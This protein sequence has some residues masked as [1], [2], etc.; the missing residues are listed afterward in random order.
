[1]PAGI[2][3]YL[4]I[5]LAV[6]LL[7]ET[8]A[9]SVSRVIVPL[10]GLPKGLD[11]FRIVHLSDLHGRYFEA[12]GQLM[13]RIR[14][15][16]PDIIALTGDY[17]HKKPEVLMHLLP[18]FAALAET[19]PVFAVPGNHDYKA[20]WPL[21]AAHLEKAGVTV[22]EN[23]SCR[24]SINGDV[25][26]VAGVHDP[27]GGRDCLDKA[28][29]EVD[30]TQPVIMLA[31][32]PTWFEK[33]CKGVPGGPGSLEKLKSNLEKISLTLCGHTHGGQIK[34]PILGAVTTGKGSWFPKR[35]IEG[36]SRENRGWLYI[37][38]GLGQGRPLPFRFLSRPELVVIT[39]KQNG[40][41]E[42]S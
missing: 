30:G 42:D 16:A 19:A 18:F 7:Y 28:L 33:V 23:G 24:L 21:I 32:A 1:M 27:S 14:E 35:Y 11:G 15:A 29:Q 17:V 25:L 41:S 13:H 34:L 37:S 5:I 36:L 8:Y 20:G 39:L 10:D 26:P 4:I 3:H 6:W 2:L 12:S 9:L 38:R 22:L 31:H 40:K